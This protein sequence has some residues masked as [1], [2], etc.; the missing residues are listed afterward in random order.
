MAEKARGLFGA[1]A[2]ETAQQDVIDRSKT[3]DPAK[4]GWVAMTVRASDIAVIELIR[5]RFLAA[6][7]RPISKPEVMS[8]AIAE[9]L[10]ILLKREDF[11]GEAADRDQS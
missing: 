3:R 11:G 2:V 1:Q 8:A 4:R 6:T 7:G 10:H 9:G 5:A